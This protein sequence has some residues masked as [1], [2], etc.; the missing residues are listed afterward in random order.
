M[1]WNWQHPEWPHF[2]WN[3]QALRQAE[4]RFLT[5]SGVFTGAFTHLD[6]EARD[7]LVIEAMSDEAITTSAIE[8]AVLDR[9]SVQSSIKRQMG[10]STIPR[11]V[12]PAERGIAE[13]MVS[14]YQT[15]TDP[16][17]H[18]TLFQW[19]RM[20]TSGRQDLEAVGNY[21]RHSEAMQIVSGPEYDAQVHYV[22]PPSD[23]I[24]ADMGRFIGWFNQT[25]PAG[26]TP[27]P[28]I[29]RAGIAHFYFEAI[30]PFEDG[31]GRIGRA[32]AEK[33]LAQGVGHTPLT[34]LAATLLRQRKGYYAMLERHNCTL[35]LS[36]WLRWFA[37]VVL[38]AQQ[39]SNQF[40][41]FLIDKTRLLDRMH[42]QLN[43][44]QEKALIRMLQEGPAG[45]EGG[46]SA[47][48]YI[49]ITGSTPPTTTRDLAGL[50]DKG[51]LLR[52]GDHRYARYHLKLPRREA[53]RFVIAED[54]AI[55]PHP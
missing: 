4:D 48:N 23:R 50:V 22:A 7:E 40:I 1:N 8:G 9:G 38:E 34:A 14:L 17:T 16:L 20:V 27:L 52:A 12:R 33:A 21:R 30:H 53:S 11:Q 6:G 37:A 36:V 2:T 26:A 19:H 25:H 42:G 55:V 24:A 31:N 45:F 43:P 15:Y 49:S 29:T 13:M 28:A 44:R 54:G 51:A 47:A 18:E 10:L 3:A 39:H 41:D 5:L 35:E 32:L 46:L